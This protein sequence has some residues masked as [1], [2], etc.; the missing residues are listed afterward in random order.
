MTN[1]SGPQHGPRNGHGPQ[2][3]RNGHGPKKAITPHHGPKNVVA[4]QHG[5]KNVGVPQQGRGGLTTGENLLSL[6][7]ITLKYL[8]GTFSLALH[9]DLENFHNLAVFD[10]CP[11][12]I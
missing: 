9:P 7:G 10:K 3:P 4:P 6:P 12:V 2:G 5:P 8:K 11:S 1:G